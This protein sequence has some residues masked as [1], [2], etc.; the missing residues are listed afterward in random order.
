LA[1]NDDAQKTEQPTQ[2]RLDQGR[3]KGQVAQSQEVKTWAALAASAFVVAVAAP[4]AAKLLLPVLTRFIEAPEAMR[5]DAADVQE[6]AMDLLLPSAAALAPLMLP[7][8]VMVLIAAIA[9]VGLMISPERIAPKLGN[10]SPLKG[11][12]RMFAL[13]AVVEVVKGLLKLAVVT[14][15]V[16]WVSMPLL[17]EVEVL[18]AIALLGLIWRTH[19]LLVALLFATAVVMTAVA[20]LDYAFQ[21]F[22]FLKQM[23][24]TRQELRDEYKD[25]EGDPH[26][27][28]RIRRIRAERSRQR[29]MAAVPK[30]TVVITNP[31]HFA[32][33]LLYEKETMPAPKVVAK[34][35]DAVAQRIRALAEASNVPVVENPPLARSLFA[36]VDIDAEIPPQHYQAVAQV[37][38]YLVKRGRMRGAA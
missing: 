20:A 26:I 18:P 24:M 29:M 19:D 30:A 16:A 15:V 25:S 37:I 23:R 27:K 35:A 21:R 9:Q 13:P 14:I 22:N 7:I 1:E 28:A 36:A 3:E 6:A 38:S 5:I 12:E 33:A 32:V 8:E 34:G 11:L 2:R 4:F 17:R 10:L 31:T